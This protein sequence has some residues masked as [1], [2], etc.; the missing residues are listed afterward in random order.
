M[1]DEVRVLILG[2]GTMAGAHAAAYA[3]IDGARVVAGVDVRPEALDAFC[4]THAIP[5]RFDSLDAALAWG[6]FDAVSNVTP[7][8]MHHATTLA[9]VAAGKH[10]LCEKPLATDHAHALEMSEAARA[11][12]VVNMINLLHRD[13]PAMHE[14]ARMVASG[15]IGRVRHVEAS[16]LQSWLTQP[17]WGDWRTDPAWL[18]RLSTAHGSTGVLG[19][20][21]IHI[22]DLA[23]HVS[24]A[25]PRHVSCRLA[26]FDKAPGGRI[27]EYT[28]DAN[29]GFA[30]HVELD[31]GAIGTI[32][33]TRFASG[34]IN[35]LRVGVHGDEGAIEAVLSQ[36]RS[37]LRACLREDLET[38]TW[39]EIATTPV[40]KSYARFIA[41]IRGGP[42]ATP[43]F[44]RG[45]ELQAILDDALHPPVT[46]RASA[47]R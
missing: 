25:R 36:G 19:D 42:V 14:A 31:G 38:A 15:A 3:A 7:D 2:T 37:R 4:R 20:I 1:T 11:A 46:N 27:G 41:A 12:G 26:T 23:T 30:M 24:G 32:G 43:D 8:A 17:A 47:S 22:L 29:D 6:A 10:V 9:A 18:W 21:G 34:H 33:A 45:A 28:L 13:V 35:D 16:Y 5:H 40:P 39:R 44:A